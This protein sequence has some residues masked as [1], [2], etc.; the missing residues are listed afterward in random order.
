MTTQ[1][2]YTFTF[3]QDEEKRFRGIRD[4][5][6]PDE[7]TI[8]TDIQKV[9]PEGGRQSQ[10][11]TVMVM[12]PEAASTFRFGMKECKIKRLRTEE[13]EA[14]VKEREDRNKVTITVKVDGLPPAAAT[15]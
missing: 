13:E 7:F 10:L 4:R 1:T 12:E 8:I 2:Q 9:D 11:T 14:A 5:L 3:N 15:P 6:D